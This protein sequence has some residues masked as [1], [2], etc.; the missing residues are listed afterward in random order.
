MASADGRKATVVERLAASPGKFEFFQVMRL[1]RQLCHD[2]Q[3]EQP[4]HGRRHG[5]DSVRIRSI[6]SFEFPE[7]S[8]SS[9]QIDQ[10]ESGYQAVS[11]V[12]LF[13][14]L[15]SQSAL[16]DLYTRLAILRKR[17][18]DHALTEFFNLFYHRLITQYYESWRKYHLAGSYADSRSERNASDNHITGSLVEILGIAASQPERIGFSRLN[19]LLYSGLLSNCSRS[20]RGLESMLSDL[21]SVPV[22]I[23][24]YSGCW[25][26]LEDSDVS[27]I[28]SDPD[29]SRYAVLGQTFVVGTRIW[30]IRSTFRVC[31]GPLDFPAFLKF[32]PTGEASAT[33]N[34]LCRFYA[35]PELDFELELHLKGAHVP[36]W[37]LGAD[38]QSGLL[39]WTTWAGTESAD[40]ADMTVRFS[41]D[42]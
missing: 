25:M 6:P 3:D 31:L 16:P 24:Q 17:A 34:S 42:S 5:S 30:D 28:S 13:G 38:E 1:L 23:Q 41:L 14:L 12:T 36:G 35:G 2:Q 21:F 39:G 15:G 20:S 22:R 37:K 33:V 18:G 11:R 27:R 19:A 4:R 26:Y 9:I 7:T 32:L 29:Q 10:T 8:V 40:S